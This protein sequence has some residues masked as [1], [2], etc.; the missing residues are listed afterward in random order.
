MAVSTFYIASS[1]SIWISSR[2]TATGGVSSAGALPLRAGC[3]VALYIQSVSPVSRGNKTTT[4]PSNARYESLGLVQC[5]HGIGSLDASPG[6]VVP[7][8][9]R[10]RSASASSRSL[11]CQ[12]IRFSVERCLHSTLDP[13]HLQ[14]FFFASAYSVTSTHHFDKPRGRSLLSP[15]ESQIRSTSSK[16]QHS[17]KETSCVSYLEHP[18]LI[19]ET[20]TLTLGS[21]N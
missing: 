1:S 15:S 4:K 5:R 19:T 10:G 12:I 9:S 17:S 18:K 20:A 14:M 21:Q 7:R 3:S 11:G 6:H 2:F 13:E 16:T 8:R